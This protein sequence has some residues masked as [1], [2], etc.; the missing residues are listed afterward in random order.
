MPIELAGIKLTRIHKIT[1]L[2]QAAFV[3]HRVPGQEGNAVQN[4]G[5][6]SV[7]LQVDGIFFGEKAKEDME[8]L[9]GVY[10]KRQPIDFIADVV[11]QYYT[12]K[13]VL[14]R[15]EVIQSASE[16]NEFGFSLIAAE[17][18]QP[19]K[20]GAGA[21]QKVNSKIKMDAKAALDIASLPDALALGS[22][23]EISNPF[24]PLKDSLEPA[25]QATEGLMQSMDGIKKLFGL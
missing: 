19:P 6:D 22:M 20:Q 4:L 24:V 5:R 15:F 11:G 13:V 3:Y 9:R 2:E 1:T 23:P 21:A 16:P 18:V 25:K 12:G 8:K 17:Y 14:D 7:R 10:I